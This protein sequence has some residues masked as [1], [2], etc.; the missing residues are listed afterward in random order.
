MVFELVKLLDID[1]ESED[2]TGKHTLEH[3][4]KIRKLL[5]VI[6]DQHPS[7]L[8]L[9]PIVY[10]YSLS[11]NFRVSCF[12]SIIS[13]IDKLTKRNQLDVFTKHRESFENIILESDLLIQQIVRKARQANKAIK[14]LISFYDNILEKLESGTKENDVLN[15]ICNSVDFSYLNQDEIRNENFSSN[16]FSKATKS[17]AF[18]LEA[19]KNA[20]RCRICGG[21]LH[22]KS[23]S[24]DHKTR[25][26][27]GGDGKLNNAQITHPYCNSTYKN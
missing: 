13:F 5:Q 26:E 9:H 20:P 15:T 18:I 19:I 27:D 10:I 23:I 25:K 22:S 8:G 4:K 2:I 1:D 16:S 17:A 3:L 7:S 11:G 12:H 24:I 14:P 6:N 21:L